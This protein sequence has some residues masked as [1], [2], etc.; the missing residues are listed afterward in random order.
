MYLLLFNA[1]FSTWPVSEYSVADSDVYPSSKKGDSTSD[2]TKL[3]A[4]DPAELRQFIPKLY[5]YG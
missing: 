3:E 5:Y 2:L 1:L 4:F